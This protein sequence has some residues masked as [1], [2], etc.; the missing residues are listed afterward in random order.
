M[1]RGSPIRRSFTSL[2]S[3]HCSPEGWPVLFRLGG[4]FPVQSSTVASK[5]VWSPVWQAPPT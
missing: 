1:C 2:A 4:T 3:L 5:Q